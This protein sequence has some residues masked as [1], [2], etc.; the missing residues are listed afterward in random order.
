MFMLCH[1]MLSLATS[2][3]ADILTLLTSTTGVERSARF[4]RTVL[5]TDPLAGRLLGSLNY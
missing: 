2:A 1:K 3:D 5:V 4:A